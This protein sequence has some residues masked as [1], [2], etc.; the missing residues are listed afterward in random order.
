[1][2]EEK[3]GSVTTPSEV[4]SNFSAVVAPMV[5]SFSENC[6]LHGPRHLHA[7]KRLIE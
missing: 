6:S 2:E 4:P 3:G 1:M 5:S 7:V